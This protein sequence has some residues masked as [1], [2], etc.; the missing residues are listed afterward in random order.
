MRR[1]R[2][3]LWL[4][5][6]AILLAGYLTLRSS[7]IL[8]SP[9][10]ARAK[11]V[12]EGDQEVAFIQ[13]ATNAATWERFVAGLHRFKSRR[14]VKKYW[15]DLVVDDSNAFPE[16]SAAVP[17]VSLSYPGCAGKLWFRWYKLSSEA[18]SEKWAKELAQRQPAPLAVI[19][20][21][22]SDRARDLAMA[23]RDQP[24][25]RGEPPV[26][27]ITTATADN[28][29]PGDAVP[30][31]ESLMTLY[32]G[33]TYRFCFTNSQMAEAIWDF[34]W[35]QEDLRPATNPNFLL[36]SGVIE[37]LGGDL[38]GSLPLVLWGSLQPQPHLVHIVEWLDDPYSRDLAH[39]FRSVFSDPDNSPT[40][41]TS[42]CVPYSV[43][44]V[45][46][47]NPREAF[48]VQTLANFLPPSPDERC[49]LILPAV[50]KPARRFLRSL[51]FAAPRE[52]GNVVAVTGDSI[53]FNTFYRDR[54]MAWNIQE[55]PV[56]VVAFFHQNPVAWREATPTGSGDVSPAIMPNDPTATDDVLMNADI[57][58]TLAEAAF[59]LQQDAA[60]ACAPRIVANSRDL[61]AEIKRRRANYFADDGNRRGG[62][63]EFLMC[64]RPLNA[65]GRVLPR[66][67][68]E[69]W[70]RR[71]TGPDHKFWERI[72][73]LDLDYGD[74]GREVFHGAS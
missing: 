6:A 11:E 24:S 21:G 38:W 51:A 74:S 58:A 19:G 2:Y 49:L 7:G 45:W 26:L 61:N 36:P 62:N 71:S 68:L 5:L 70:R 18:D 12:P 14:N 1:L 4:G 47:P 8:G 54:Q 66:A 56:P 55:L 37:A 43:G 30:F 27:M 52:I 40:P 35:T 65:A 29:Y 22:S 69:V 60:S 67:S 34:V 42:F 16:Q 39:Q 10:Q 25:W 20:G 57:V 23:L 9:V 17:E 53:G 46:I 41:L 73:K 28:V 64:L 44:D 50:D 59:G 63:G 3:L 13:A 33:G 31:P 72:K 48:V 15:P 32:P